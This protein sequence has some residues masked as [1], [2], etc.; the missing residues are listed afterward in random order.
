MRHI[1]VGDLSVQDKLREGGLELCE[2]LRSGNPADIFANT[3]ELPTLG[4]ILGR[5]IMHSGGTDVINLPAVEAICRRFYG[6]M[7]A[8][9]DVHRESDWQK[10]KVTKASGSPRSSGRSWTSMTSALSTPMTW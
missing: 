9:E 5:L 2:V 8:F 6:L 1:A 3:A 10:P 4:L 7:R